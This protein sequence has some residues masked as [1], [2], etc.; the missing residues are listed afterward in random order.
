MPPRGRPR[1]RVWCIFISCTSDLGS[2]LWVLT[3]SYLVRTL[4][5]CIVSSGRAADIMI[6][7]AALGN[8]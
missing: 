3:V 4:V 8:S 1:C 2:R 5:P 7:L 6:A